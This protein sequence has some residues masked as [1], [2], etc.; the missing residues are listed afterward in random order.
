MTPESMTDT[1][2]SYCNWETWKWP[3]RTKAEQPSAQWP[4]KLYVLYFWRLIYKLST[5]HFACIFLFVLLG[6]KLLENRQ[7][8]FGLI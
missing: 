3:G 7:Y 1:L 4:V 6:Y 8:D 5:Y 2:G